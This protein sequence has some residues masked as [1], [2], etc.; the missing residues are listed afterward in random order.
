MEGQAPV[1]TLVCHPRRS[2]SSRYR[3]WVRLT[4]QEMPAILDHSH[5]FTLPWAQ[6]RL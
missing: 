1:L 3:Q 5:L 4:K 6:L 2:S